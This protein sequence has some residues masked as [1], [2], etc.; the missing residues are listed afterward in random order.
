[1]SLVD[2]DKNT[3]ILSRRLYDSS[4]ADMSKIHIREVLH[5]HIDEFLAAGGEIQ[6]IE[7][8]ESAYDEERG[9]GVLKYSRRFN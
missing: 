9:F 2:L 5:K 6:V 1:M 7:E 4:W 8:G 3:I